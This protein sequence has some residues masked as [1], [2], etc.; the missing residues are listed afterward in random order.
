MGQWCLL[1]VAI[2]HAYLRHRAGYRHAVGAGSGVMISNNP[3]ILGH[4]STWG[5]ERMR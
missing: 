1:G 2:S 5:G 4:R 3:L